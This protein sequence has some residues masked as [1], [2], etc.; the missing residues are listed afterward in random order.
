VLE[1]VVAGKL[2]KQIASALQV[3]ERTIKTLRAQVHGQAG[4]HLGLPNLGILVERLR[5]GSEG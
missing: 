1:Q 5:R 3:S 4:R 2:N